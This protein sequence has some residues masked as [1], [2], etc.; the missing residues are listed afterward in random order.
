MDKQ[1]VS[2]IGN[3]C[4]LIRQ[5]CASRSCKHLVVPVLVVS[6]SGGEPYAS[7]VTGAD[8]CWTRV[9]FPSDV[10]FLALNIGRK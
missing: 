2:A 9:P 8:G 7:G 5:L 6:S 10:F 1:H 4:A 3:T